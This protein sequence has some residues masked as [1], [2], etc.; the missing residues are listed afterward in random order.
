[1]TRDELIEL[2]KKYGKS[3]FFQEFLRDELKKEI[4]N[5]RVEVFNE[6][7]RKNG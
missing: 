6:K 1:L 3:S 5:I 4:N 7:E 2:N